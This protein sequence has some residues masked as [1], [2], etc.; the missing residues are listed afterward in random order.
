MD[1]LKFLARPVHACPKSLDE[2]SQVNPTNTF[3]A[4]SPGSSQCVL[5]EETDNV[6]K[7]S[8]VLEGYCQDMSCSGQCH[9]F[10]E[11]KRQFAT[12]NWHALRSTT[13][14]PHHRM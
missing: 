14:G 13:R 1:G 3:E 12:K 10:H 11:S 6:K 5:A 4:G 7:P 8:K 2:F 9:T